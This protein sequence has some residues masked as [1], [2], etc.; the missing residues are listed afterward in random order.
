[1]SEF[2]LPPQPSDIVQAVVQQLSAKSTGRGQSVPRTLGRTESYT[3]PITDACNGSQHYGRSLGRDTAISSQNETDNLEFAASDWS[4]EQRPQRC[5]LQELPSEIQDLILDFLLGDLVAVSSTSGNASVRVSAAMRHPRR[6]E[7]SDMALVNKTWRDLVQG[8]IF[9]HIKIKGTR[10]GLKDSEDFFLYHGH[11][12]RHVRHIEVWIPV[13]GDRSPF[14]RS[15]PTHLG[16]RPM[17]DYSQQTQAAEIFPG[18]EIAVNFRRSTQNATMPE[19]F[20]HVN[21]FFPHA[22][23][24]TLEGGH[25]KNANVVGYFP[26]RQTHPSYETPSSQHSYNVER[27]L[28][29]MPQIRTFVIKGAWNI[30]RDYAHWQAIE[31]ALPNLQDWHCNYAQVNKQAY[32]LVNQIFL[33][34][35]ST[36]RRISVSME[37]LPFKDRT[38]WFGRLPHEDHCEQL[39]R[40]APRLESIS[41]AGKMCSDIFRFAAAVARHSKADCRLQSIDLSVHRACH[42]PH[43]WDDHQEFWAPTSVEASPSITNLDFIG[44]FEQLV[45]SCIRSMEVLPLKNIRIRYIDL[46]SACPQLN[47]YFQ[48]SNN[49]CHGLWNEEILR[50]LQKFRSNARYAE[51][52]D[53]LNDQYRTQVEKGEACVRS[54]YPTKRPK[55]IKSSIYRTLNEARATV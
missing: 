23:I 38:F 39:G 54:L 32:L 43:P 33:K 20:S 7:L 52:T 47:P 55:A 2:T 5:G 37:G 14:I 51:L 25:C 27:R 30:M 40:I 8:R 21:C 48:L 10:E 34:M 44:A 17:P 53:G 18:Q 24:F 26:E 15:T 31:E 13:W 41:F 16:A 4:T 46:D 22:C 29:R 36:V 3:S 9:R 49:V 1:M 6:K 50:L 11:L 19:I 45:T 12:T 28:E 42:K 35:P